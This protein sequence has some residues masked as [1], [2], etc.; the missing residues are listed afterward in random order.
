MRVDQPAKGLQLS[1]SYTSAVH[2]VNKC[3]NPFVRSEFVLF[4][5]L[6]ISSEDFYVG[7]FPEINLMYEK[8]KGQS[9]I[10]LPFTDT[11]AYEAELERLHSAPGNGCL[12]SAAIFDVIRCVARAI[13]LVLIPGCWLHVQ[14]PRAR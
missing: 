10:I 14:H 2:H 6:E 3:D 12:R 1:V 13:T 9:I 4:S 8:S 7:T 5:S 11:T